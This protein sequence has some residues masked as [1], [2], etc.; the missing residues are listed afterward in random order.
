MSEIC[1][2]WSTWLKK[3][4]FSYM[5]ELQV[6]QTLNWLITIRDQ[7]LLLADIKENQK[8]ADFGCGSGLLGF[9]VIEKF[10]DSVEVIFSDKFQDCLDECANIL[11]E[12]TTP[13]RVCFLQSDVSNIKLESNYLDRAMTR[14]V[15]VHIKEKQPAFNELYRVLKPEGYYCAFE[16]I[17]SQNTRYYELLLP[18]QISD[19]FD[20]KKA[21]KEFMENEND[22]L[23]NFNAESLDKNMIEAGFSDVKVEVQVVAS[24]YAPSKNAILSWFI[25][26][27]APDQKTMKERFLEYFEEKKVDNFISEVQNA[28]ADKEIKVSSNTALIKAIK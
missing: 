22:P 24:K 9:G 5:N 15:L 14:S 17:I 13:H 3:T 19:Y 8:V 28:L 12:S 27:P 21:E 4:R 10:K 11:K 1:E 16:P 7:V 25:A 20:F 18:N 2:N 23:V 6:Q 26:P